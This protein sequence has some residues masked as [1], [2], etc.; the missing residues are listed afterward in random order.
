M[1]FWPFKKKQKPAPATTPSISPAKLDESGAHGPAPVASPPEAAGSDSAADATPVA[2]STPPPLPPAAAPAVAEDVVEKATSE[3]PAA[4]TKPEVAEAIEAEVPANAE[5][6]SVP[7]SA[8]EPPA[9]DISA[10]AEPAP[11]TS[12]RAFKPPVLAPEPPN[13]TPPPL[14]PVSV[15][16]P[17]F[18][19]PLAPDPPKPLVLE[20]VIPPSTLP[21]ESPA[22]APAATAP[23]E[24]VAE[25]AALTPPLIP[26]EAPAAAAPDAPDI[27]TPPLPAFPAVEEP[28]VEAPPTP[29]A[30]ADEPPPPAESKPELVTEESAAT[31]PTFRTT[32]HVAG[33]ILHGDG[34][35]SFDATHV[36]YQ[37]LNAGDPPVILSIPVLATH[38]MAAHGPTQHLVIS[39][40]GTLS[41]PMIGAVTQVF[42]YEGD[43]RVTGQ[44]VPADRAATGGALQYSAAVDVPG[45]IINEDG[46]YLLDPT[47]AAYQHLQPGERQIYAIPVTAVTADGQSDVRELVV[48]ITGRD[49]GAVAAG[50]AAHSMPHGSCVLHDRIQ[51]GPGSPA[52]LSYRTSSLVPGFSLRPDGAWSFDSAHPFYTDVHEGAVRIITVPV[53][54]VDDHGN[55]HDTKA[56]SITLHGTSGLPL[57]S[58]MVVSGMDGGSFVQGSLGVHPD[59][60]AGLFQFSYI[61]ELP[62]GF[63]LG[64]DGT[65]SF[66]ASPELYGYLD[67]GHTEVVVAQVHG[68]DGQGHI[69]GSM[70][71]ITVHGTPGDP[72][73]GAVTI[74]THQALPEYDDPSLGTETPDAGTD[75]FGLLFDDALLP[76]AAQ[77]PGSYGDFLG[78]T[79][80]QATESAES[81]TASGEPTEG[82]LL[83]QPEPSAEEPQYDPAEVQQALQ[84]LGYGHLVDPAPGASQ[85]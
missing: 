39:V 13:Y 9:A 46:S 51:Q 11:T 41:G 42:T 47:D 59:A 75:S 73:V 22:S 18:S 25:K 65:W 14:P 10:E 57:L 69:E 27:V 58:A 79:E 62:A 85:S 5:G 45:L 53:T 17:K 61:G 63:Q 29:E 68:E 72:S 31:A 52:H 32:G 33:F 35:W 34:T 37:H 19:P 26:T 8:P 6:A 3:A 16:P 40:Q 30:A 84:S 24:A 2:P 20:N 60:A 55:T 70:V 21:E 66:H 4:E 80:H 74:S 67:A 36:A 82:L 44:I 38:A 78:E 54:A 49:D 48:G 64:V 81:A 56:I 15:E 12:R 50:I 76:G 83:D 1:N 43:R 71:A 77:E 7:A 28:A 23:T